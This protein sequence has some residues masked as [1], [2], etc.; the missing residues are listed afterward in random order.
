MPEACSQSFPRSSPPNNS[1]LR[2]QNAVLR[3]GLPGRLFSG[4]YCNRE[5]NR[6]EKFAEH[7]VG[8]HF[9]HWSLTYICKYC[10]RNARDSFLPAKSVL[11]WSFCTTDH[12]PLAS[13]KPHFK[14]LPAHWGWEGIL[15][16]SSVKKNL[17][18][19]WFLFWFGNLEISI[20]CL[21]L[22][23]FNYIGLTI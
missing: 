13:H 17:T 22:F 8:K 19:Y 12:E 6:L 23:N 14:F 1:W 10:R 15:S 11:G 7:I 20:L 2:A 9:S 16:Y 5:K 4:S 18:P 3:Q 21:V